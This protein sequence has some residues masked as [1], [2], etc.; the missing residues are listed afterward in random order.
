MRKRRSDII[1]GSPDFVSFIKRNWKKMDNNALA[2]KYGCGICS[3][4]KQ[5]YDLG[6]LR[7]KLE[8]WTEEQIE[9]LKNNYRIMGDTELAEIFNKT[10]KKKK[11]WTIKH[12]EKKRIYLKLKRT[13][14]QLIEIEQRNLDQGR[15]NVHKKK[16]KSKFLTK[17]PAKQGEIR[18]YLGPNGQTITSKIRIGKQWLYWPRWAYKK[19][20]GAIPKDHVI[21]LKDGDPYNTVPENL[22]AVTRGES[23]RRYA[24]K[25]SIN[26]SD[27]YVAAQMAYGNPE[28]RKEIKTNPDLIETYRTLML[29]KRKIKLKKNEQQKPGRRAA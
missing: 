26:L 20:I 7:M 4:R 27:G 22:E 15:L 29:L 13:K 2:K 11:T 19:Y 3:V 14:K 12:I 9:F 23:T 5:C 25:T 8:Y 18:M 21:V 24:A 6:L 17:G 16:G 10:F 28:L 1:A